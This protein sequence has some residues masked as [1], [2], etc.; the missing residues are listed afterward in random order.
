M[1]LLLAVVLA[2][3]L[4]QASGSVPD[5]IRRSIEKDRSDTETWLKSGET[6]YLATIVRTDF[7][8]RTTLRVGRAAD[9]DV[10]LDADSVAAHHLEVTVV[11]DSFRVVARDPG[12]AFIAGKAS[13]RSAVVGPSS[14]RVGRYTLRL[15]HQRF[16][17]II[18]F[19]PRSPRFKDYKGL[20]YYP[21]DLAYRYVVSLTPSPRPD[22][23]I[24]LSTR[25]NRRRAL[26]VGWFD[27]KVGTTSCRLEATRLLEPG[28]DEHS[29]SVFFRD[30]TS[31]KDT[32]AVGRYVDPTP[33]PD[34]RYVLDFNAAYN[35]A[36]AFSP[37]YNC[38][39]PPKDNTLTAAI[40]AGEMDSHYASH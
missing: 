13:L 34:G 32:Y 37:H 17:A 40:R 20:R 5:S 25:G 14:I 28:V 11:G 33:Q 27:F 31:G 18:V 24:I 26:R 16:P 6:S 7:G 35:P 38:P 12:A 23:V 19:D 3:A 15:S 10:R 4:P 21:V 39:L 9:N 1:N 29:V 2:L 30:A 8:G 36:C 22:T